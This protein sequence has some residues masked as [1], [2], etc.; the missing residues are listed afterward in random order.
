MFESWLVRE[1]GIELSTFVSS[2]TEYSAIGEDPLKVI[3]PSN[4]W[5][6]LNLFSKIVVLLIFILVQMRQLGI[7]V[8]HLIG[9]HIISQLKWHIFW[10]ARQ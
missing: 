2:N 7:Y 8:S 3:V 9:Q 5:T 1:I 6:I 10:I 4:F